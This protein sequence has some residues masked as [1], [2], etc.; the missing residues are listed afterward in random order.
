MKEVIAGGGVIHQI[1]NPEHILVI[2]RNAVWDLPK[3]KLEEGEDIP[4][5]ALREVVEETGVSGVTI[6]S[7]IT[8]TVHNYK[9][10]GAVHRKTTHWYHMQ[11]PAEQAFKPQKIEGIE[12]VQWMRKAEAATKLGYENL[13]TVLRHDS[14]Q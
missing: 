4:A 8:K 11:A 12:R 3:G 7:F 2:Y 13:R 1:E 14:P 5:C 10:K 6:G 9:R